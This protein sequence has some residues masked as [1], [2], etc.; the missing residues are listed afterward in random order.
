MTTEKI[1]WR[2][3]MAGVHKFINLENPG[4]DISMTYRNMHIRVK[5]GEERNVPKIFITACLGL[6]IAKDTLPRT[7][8][9]HQEGQ[10]YETVERP[11]YMAVKV[12]TVTDPIQI[13]KERAIDEADVPAK[14]KKLKKLKPVADVEA[15]EEEEEE[16]AREG[17][18]QQN[19][20]DDIIKDL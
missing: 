16:E 14:K 12:E 7:D 13:A 9:K 5:H 17:R 6:A 2:T 4:E 11:R 3:D 20:R 10:Q 8:V 19:A 18:R 1:D 15:V